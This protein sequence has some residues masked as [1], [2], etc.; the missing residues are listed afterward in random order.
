MQPAL[1]HILKLYTTPSQLLELSI[2]AEEK[3]KNAKWGESLVF[4]SYYIDG[5]KIEFVIDQEQI[6]ID[7]MLKGD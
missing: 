5:V 1:I 2:K 6:K 7:E 3:Y 4:E